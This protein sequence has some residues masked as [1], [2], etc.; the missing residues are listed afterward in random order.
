MPTLSKNIFLHDLLVFQMAHSHQA[1]ISNW[2]ERAALGQ[3]EARRVLAEMLTPSG[4]QSFFLL[5]LAT[6][7]DIYLTE[8]ITLLKLHVLVIGTGH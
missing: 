4:N 7:L 8:H 3:Q 2:R 1:L 6:T 5:V